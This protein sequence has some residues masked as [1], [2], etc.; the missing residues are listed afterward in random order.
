MKN[1]EAVLNEQIRGLDDEET[2]I[3]GISLLKDDIELLDKQL[4]ILESQEPSVE[5]DIR[6]EQIRSERKKKEERQNAYLDALLNVLVKY[7]SKRLS[8]SKTYKKYVIEKENQKSFADDTIHR[9]LLKLVKTYFKYID[10]Y[11]INYSKLPFSYYID[12]FVNVDQNNKPERGIIYDSTLLDKVEE[13]IENPAAD[14][15][16]TEKDTV[17]KLP[18]L[19][20]QL[21]VLQESMSPEMFQALTLYFQQFGELDSLNIPQKLDE[22]PEII[23]EL[24]SLAGSETREGV[25]EFLIQVL[26]ATMEA[27]N[28]FVKSKK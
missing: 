23:D 7:G 5:T 18:N 2:I 17:K 16:I 13:E 9:Y 15:S 21:S 25:E 27:K 28:D 19:E 6:K 20:Q 8:N 1:E 4:E 26:E 22:F 12:N 14:E 24:K 10:D 11:K 3:S